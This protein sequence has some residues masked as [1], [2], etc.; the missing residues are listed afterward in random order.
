MLEFV[1]L[2]N[3]TRS[4]RDFLFVC[5]FT[6]SKFPGLYVGGTE[7]LCALKTWQLEIT[8]SVGHLAYALVKFKE[9]CHGN[10]SGEWSVCAAQGTCSNLVSRHG[11]ALSVIKPFSEIMNRLWFL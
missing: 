4:W 8:K 10:G 7:C 2:L 6:S 11:N 1:D 3:P 9:I 5:E